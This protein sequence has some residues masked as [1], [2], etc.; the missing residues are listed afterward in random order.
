MSGQDDDHVATDSPMWQYA[1]VHFALEDLRSAADRSGRLGPRVLILGGSA[2]GKTTLAKLLSAYA[3]KAERKPI[4]VGLDPREG[5][6]SVPGS[7]TATVMGSLLDVEEGWGSSPIS[8]PSAVPV[9]TPLCYHFGCED[10]FEN[11]RLYKAQVS[12]LANA[13]S[14]KYNEDPE[15]RAS[16]C[17]IDT[18]ASLGNGTQDSLEI[19]QHII[20]S[21]NSQSP[22]LHL[23]HN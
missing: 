16:G 15:I 23:L 20:S 14:G 12:R 6:F 10:V 19:I 11:E 2:S 22:H 1:N 3:I 9:K 7:L 13:V 8:G 4:V 5:L 17:I 21:Y 18:P